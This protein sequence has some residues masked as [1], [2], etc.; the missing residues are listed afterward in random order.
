MHI[1]KQ[2]LKTAVALVRTTNMP[3]VFAGDYDYDG[4]Y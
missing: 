2:K 4:T 3:I 1:Q